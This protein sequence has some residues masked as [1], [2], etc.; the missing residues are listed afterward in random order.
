LAE[1]T[2]QDF[3][4]EVLRSAMKYQ[5]MSIPL[6]LFQGGEKVNE[7]LGLVPENMI[8]PKAAAPV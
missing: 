4:K 3:D 8:R 7:N 1:I 6:V 2:H 5:V